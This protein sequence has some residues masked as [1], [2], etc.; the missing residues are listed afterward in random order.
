MFKLILFFNVWKYYRF[1]TIF[2]LYRLFAY[3]YQKTANCA[4]R[5]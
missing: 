4:E 3:F 1:T 2:K 5:P